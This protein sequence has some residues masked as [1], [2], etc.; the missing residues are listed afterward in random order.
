[1]KKKDV[2]VTNK[3]IDSL[4]GEFISFNEFLTIASS[5]EG[6]NLSGTLYFD[7][8]V[9][10]ED[11]YNEIK[12]MDSVKIFTTDENNIPEYIN[13]EILKLIEKTEAVEPDNIKSE[14]FMASDIAKRALKKEGKNLDRANIINMINK[15]TYENGENEVFDNK[16]ARVYLFGSSKGGTGKTFTSLISAYRFAKVNPELKIA[17]SDF[18]I[19]DGQIGITIHK[20]QPTMYDF[21]KQWK[22][23]NTDF[24][25]MR[26]YKTN[27]DKFPSN[28]DFYL[29]PKDV[30]IKNDNFW[31][32]IFVNLIRNYD[33]VF[34]DSGI[35][36]MNYSPI[37]TLYKIADK[38]ILISTTSIK[39]VSSVVKQINRLKG[40][41]PNEI[42]K[43]E[44]DIGKKLNLVI[45]QVSEDDN[46]NETVFEL[47]R[48]NIDIIAT[49]GII[50]SDIQKAEYLGEWDIFDNK[51]NFNNAL[52]RI[53]KYP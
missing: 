25:T 26:K 1:M 20:M 41:I 23:G 46:M 8:D 40:V 3:T 36:Y 14:D 24:A 28:I 34:F 49:F 10:T 29:A 45:T 27:Y 52:D 50:T 15:N 43:K 13:E 11:V 44:D 51:K 18:D 9:L 30:N 47:F 32:S 53:T 31:K 12:D 19:I 39:S 48:S 5:E 21:F 22:L 42:F 2:I 35:D 33:V 4:N 37:S 38:I 7:A 16:E 6:I 17:V